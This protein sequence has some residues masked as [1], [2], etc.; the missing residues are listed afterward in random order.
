MVILTFASRNPDSS[1][2]ANNGPIRQPYSNCLGISIPATPTPHIMLL[3]IPIVRLQK[4]I[5]EVMSI[6]SSLIFRSALFNSLLYCDIILYSHRLRSSSKQRDIAKSIWC[7][8]QVHIQK[9]KCLAKIS[10]RKLR[11]RVGN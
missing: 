1:L 6:V 3:Y 11:R 5:I 4:Y 10:R 2:A 7:T 9:A 8:S